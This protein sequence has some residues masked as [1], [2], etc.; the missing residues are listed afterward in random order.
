MR[1]LLVSISAP[2]KNSAESI[3][4]GRYLKHLTE[5]HEVTLLTTKV[6]G[7]WE[8]ADAGLEHYLQKVSRRIELSNLHPRIISVIKKFSP[9]LLVPDEQIFFTMQVSGAIKAIGK[10]PNLII[11]RSAPFSS[12]L[13]ASKLALHWNVPWLMHLSDLWVDS[14]F[15]NLSPKTHNRQAH[16]ERQSFEQATAI[17]V[18]SKK[19]MDFFKNKYPGLSSKIEFLPNVFEDEN[20][21]LTPVEFKGKLQMVFTGRL[22]GTRSVHSFLDLLH[23][24]FDQYPNSANQIQI[25]LAGFV[26]DANIKLVQDSGLKMIQ[27][28][29][30]LS[31]KDA[32]AL[33]RK[34]H[35]LVLID[36]WDE[37][38]RYD[39]FFPSKLL[40]YI[41][42][43]RFILALTR[44]NSTTYDVVEGKFG[45]CFYPGNTEQFSEFMNRLIKEFQ[46]QNSGFFQ[47]S[48]DDAGRQYADRFNAER[49]ET[50]IKKFAK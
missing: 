13:M 15:L 31:L 22:Y 14:P 6:Q 3:Q 25:S 7:G 5:N 44:K 39:F 32:L 10:K 4:T 2:P 45:R 11:S 12:A 29:G 42:A 37:D 30:P 26:E 24:F 46:N 36:S 49:L 21:N 35:V 16:L 50:M 18:T 27:Y 23:K 20:V 9:Q 47:F 41:A 40:D 43:N 34:S 1:I 48:L 38:A 28:L 17:T 8:P 33:Q 19:V